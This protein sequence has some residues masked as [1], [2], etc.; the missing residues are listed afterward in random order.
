MGISQVRA[1]TTATLLMVKPI[2]AGGVVV[3]GGLPCSV[4]LAPITALSGC[5]LLTTLHGALTAPPAAPT[6]Q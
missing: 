1:M 6:P 4:A 3:L 2:T 5:L